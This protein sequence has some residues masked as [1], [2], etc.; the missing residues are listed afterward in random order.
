M[1]LEEAGFKETKSG[2]YEILNLDLIRNWT[3]EVA[4]MAM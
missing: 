2:V 3:K 4:K 1:Q